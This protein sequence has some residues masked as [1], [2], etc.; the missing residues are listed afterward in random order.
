VNQRA[1]ATGR[2]SSTRRAAAGGATRDKILRCAERLFAKEGIDRVT[3]RQ[4]A[5]G[6][7]QRNVA[8]VQYHFGSKDELLRCIVGRHQQ[9][10]DGR[11]RALL[12]GQGP[13]LE[14]ADLPQLIEILVEPLVVQLDTASGRDYLQI[15]TQRR[16]R[17]PLLPATE[18]LAARI[19]RVRSG[20][21]DPTLDGFVV[22]LLFNALAERARQESSRRREGREAFVAALI[23]ALGRLYGDNA[24]GS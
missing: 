23:G 21:A 22:L 19:E 1:N 14:T 2:G 17:D 8:A 4:I 6:A 5:R 3:L 24:Q 9:E 12:D 16:E 18:E 11:R 20:P 7:D 10:V 15:Q 13:G